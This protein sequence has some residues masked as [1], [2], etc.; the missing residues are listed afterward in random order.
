MLAHDNRR[1]A[2]RNHSPVRWLMIVVSAASAFSADLASAQFRVQ[3]QNV[4]AM[5]L[6]N[7]QDEATYRQA[8]DG[9]SMLRLNRITKIANLNTEQETKLQLAIRGDLHRFY[10]EMDIVKETTKDFD[11]QNQADMQKAWQA[12]A[13]LRTKLAT[14]LDGEDSLFAKV[15]SSTLNIEQMETYEQY[16]SDRQV[17][18]TRAVI[19]MTVSDMEKLV[20]LLDVQRQQLVELLESQKFPRKVPQ[21]FEVM[22]GYIILARLKDDALST[23]LDDSQVKVVAQMQKQYDGFARSVTW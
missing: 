18:T 11:M 22:V 20:P 2:K 6:F 9:R 14:G 17:A 15:L 8:L 4:V 7:G 10:R 12:V 1:T 21:G 13:P 23:I 5:F 19:R 16:L 3:Q